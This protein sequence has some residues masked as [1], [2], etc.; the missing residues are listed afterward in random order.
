MRMTNNENN[1][2]W[3]L[4]LW[5]K[6]QATKMH[7]VI[8]LFLSFILIKISTYKKNS[9][10]FLKRWQCA[11]LPILPTWKN[12]KNIRISQQQNNTN[13]C[14][15]SMHTK[16]RRQTYHVILISSISSLERCW[17]FLIIVRKHFNFLLLTIFIFLLIEKLIENVWF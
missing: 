3:N 2:I 1:F 12:N 6:S 11:V 8:I 7:V 15:V 16:H 17:N 13:K 14:F 5:K 4:M 9:K 10:S